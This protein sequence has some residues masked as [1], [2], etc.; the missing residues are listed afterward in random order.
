[1]IKSA[2]KALSTLFII[3]AFSSSYAEERVITM[4]VSQSIYHSGILSYFIPLFEKRMPYRI[5]AIPASNEEAISMGR[6][7]RADLLF[8]KASDYSEEF[9]SEGFGTNRWNVMHNISVII[10]PNDDPAGIRGREPIE[11]F[12]KI[13]KGGYPFISC[14]NCRDI[15]RVEERLWKEAGIV[16]E[17][18]WYMSHAND[19]E[20]L[21]RVANSRLGYALI[22]RPEYLMLKEKIRL[23]ILVDRNPLLLNQ[24]I[25]IE[26]NPA[27][28][29]LVNNAG[30]R[31]FAEYVTSGEGEDIIRRFGL[32]RYGEQAFFPQ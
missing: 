21:I 3:A 24:Y 8:L 22:D 18:K 12:K 2:I 23:D 10:G 11:A 5:K 20:D 25:I 32:D 4:A 28:F 27:K 9:I 7:G 16:P 26:I 29:P 19:M 15:K 31:A 14:S 6:E 13:A 30:A 1:M 17:E